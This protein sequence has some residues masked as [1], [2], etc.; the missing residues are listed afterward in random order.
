MGNTT[1]CP[2]CKK[3]LDPVLDKDVSFLGCQA[4]FGLF[5]ADAD[6]E[7][8]VVLSATPESAASFKK[9]LARAKV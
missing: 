2:R 4:C 1:P 7:R 6:L 9:L 5:V 3:P 8:Y